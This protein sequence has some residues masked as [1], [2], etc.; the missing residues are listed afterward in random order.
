MHRVHILFRV[1][2]LMHKHSTVAVDRIE[3]NAR[4]EHDKPI[5]VISYELKHELRLKHFACENIS[6]NIA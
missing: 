5:S 6:L 1:H 4:E 3:K 2:V